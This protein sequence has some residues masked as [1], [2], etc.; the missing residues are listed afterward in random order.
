MASIMED[1]ISTLEQEEVLYT[2]LLEISKRKTSVIVKGDLEGITAVTQEE[3]PLVDKIGNLDKHR[4]EVLTDISIVLNKKEEELTIPN[5][6]ALLK[7]QPEQQKQLSKV[8]DRLK[9]VISDMRQTNEQNASLIQLSLDMI[10]FDL[11]LLRSAKKA[12]ETNDYTRRGGYSN[13]GLSYDRGYT[14]GGF[15]AKQ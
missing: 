2:R 10:Q 14:S 8:Y 9:T 4:L 12:P 3:Q 13:A 7:K 15:D 6:I 1:F 5:I 11:D